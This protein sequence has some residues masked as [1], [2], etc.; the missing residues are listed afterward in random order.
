MRLFKSGF[1]GLNVL[2]LV[3]TIIIASGC[4]SSTEKITDPKNKKVALVYGYVNMNE[5]GSPLD[6]L[7]VRRYRPTPQRYGTD[8]YAGLFFHIGVDLGSYQVERFGSN[9][10]AFRNTSYRYT[11]GGSGKNMSARRINKPGLHYLGSYKYNAKTNSSG[12]DYFTFDKVK[13]PSEKELLTILLRRVKSDY[14]EY[15]QQIKWIEQRLAQL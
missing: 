8:I 14:S 5:A 9:S 4:S 10:G 7:A 11:F 13:E 2:F 12:R 6:W 3:A 15:T 1:M